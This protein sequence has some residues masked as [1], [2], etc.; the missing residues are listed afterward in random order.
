M[1][2][3]SA[4]PLFG[5]PPAALAAPQAVQE[6]CA[7]I[8]ALLT[9]LL[10]WASRLGRLGRLLAPHLDAV[11]GCLR[12]L[13]TLFARLAAGDLHAPASPRAIAPPAPPA[14][15]APARPSRPLNPPGARLAS[16]PARTAPLAP[17]GRAS[18]PTAHLP[19][20]HRLA[21][22]A[23]E[24]QQSRLPA[25]EMQKTPSPDDR[26]RSSILLRYSNKYLMPSR[27]PTPCL[28]CIP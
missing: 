23:R 19:A 16:R 5:I 20:R 4:Q 14:P 27:N 3:A 10:L 28:H 26:F 1:N 24:P 21:S 2:S 6:T 17:A 9:T 18:P 15:P 12:A 22:T 7:R 13:S 11:A 25:T 8:D